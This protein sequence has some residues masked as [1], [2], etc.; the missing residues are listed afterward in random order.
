MVKST[1]LN[2][3]HLNAFL[4]LFY[5]P[6]NVPEIPGS[7]YVTILPGSGLKT[8]MRRTG[9][10]KV[11]IQ[12]QEKLV[13]AQHTQCP[14][15]LSQAVNIPIV[16]MVVTIS[17]SFSLYKMVVFPAASKPT[18]RIRISFFPKRLLNNFSKTFPIVTEFCDL[19][20]KKSKPSN[21]SLQRYGHINTRHTHEIQAS[22]G[23]GSWQ[24]LNNFKYSLARK[25]LSIL[26][27]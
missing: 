27:S 22:T 10:S 25:E 11:K 14:R 5:K 23:G 18:I 24:N 6:S 13:K 19:K 3:F 17:P 12:Q 21:G 1:E 8:F 2:L 15:V 16:G 7:T 26:F 4:W 20:E 9:F